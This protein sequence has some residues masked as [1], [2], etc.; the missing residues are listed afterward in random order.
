VGNKVNGRQ[1]CA[2]HTVPGRVGVTVTVTSKLPIEHSDRHERR[3]SAN[4]ELSTGHL[5]FAACGLRP[6]N[7]AQRGD[8]AISMRSAARAL[9]LGQS[10]HGHRPK[11]RGSDSIH[12]CFGLLYFPRPPAREYVAFYTSPL[13]PRLLAICLLAAFEETKFRL[14]LMTLLILAAVALWRKTPPAWYFVLIIVVAQFANVGGL[15]L[16]DPMYGSLRY[17]ALGSVWGWLYW[18]HGWLSALT[19]HSTTHLFLDPLLFF[20]LQ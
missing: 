4:F 1:T 10:G 16:H 5:A 15:V 19:G 20:G 13:M 3:S 2:V 9:S 14:V 17:L 6:V 8:G 12:P 18:K 7:G 11:H